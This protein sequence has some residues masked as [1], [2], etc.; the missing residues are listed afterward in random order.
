MPNETNSKSVLEPPPPAPSENDGRG[1]RS[2]GGWAQKWA[3]RGGMIVYLLIVIAVLVVV[4]LVVSRRDHS[5][6]LTKNHVHS[7]S[8]ESVKI[9]KELRAPLQLTYFDRAANF[10]HAREFFGRYQ[11]ESNEVKVNLVDPDRHPELARLDKIESYGTTLVAYGGRT[12]LVNNLDEQDVTNA[13]VRVLKGG[14]KIVYFTAGEGER[15][16]DDTG[17]GGY[18]EFKAE[19]TK[20]N[21]T[22]KTLV[23]AQTPAVPADCSILVV[24]GPTRGFV[25]PEVNAIADYLQRGGRAMF[26]LGAASANGANGAAARPL[27][28]YLSQTLDVKMTPDIVVDASG[29]GRLFGASELMPIVYTY[30]SHPITDPMR[31]MA[32]MFPDARTVQPGDAKNAAA[33]VEPLLET[34]PQSFAA[35]DFSGGEVRVNPATALRGPLTL[36]VAGTMSALGPDHKPATARFVVYG[37]PDI[38]ANAILPFNGNQDLMMNSMNWLAAQESFISIRPQQT[39]NTPLNLTAAQMDWIFWSVLVILPIIIIL[40]G[41]LVWW[42]RRSA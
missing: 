33:T 38:A 30:D 42:R 32:T 13:M 17:R 35:T 27:L 1:P 40:I 6:D 4:N 23:L 21:F 31:H 8:P 2:E 39:S 22:V 25:Q 9:V 36:G 7:L 18:S 12:Q 11:R 37:S 5:W 29:V 15:D 16:P 34:S 3:A 19:L 24:A 14:P 28:Q 10:E 20:E 41:G 26:L